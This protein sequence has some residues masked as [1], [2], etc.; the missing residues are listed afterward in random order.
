MTVEAK[1][2]ARSFD[3]SQDLEETLR[4]YRAVQEVWES[5]ESVGIGG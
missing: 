4:R 2:V 1:R 3:L 5:L